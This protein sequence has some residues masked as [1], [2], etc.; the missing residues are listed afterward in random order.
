MPWR[1]LVVTQTLR[2]CKMWRLAT[3]PRPPP[4]TALN[5]VHDSLTIPPAPTAPY[6]RQRHIQIEPVLSTIALL[7]LVLLIAGWR[8]AGPEQHD[9]VKGQGHGINVAVVPR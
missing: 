7:A 5:T 3:R 8:P 2:P 6:R 9:G 1:R 4:E